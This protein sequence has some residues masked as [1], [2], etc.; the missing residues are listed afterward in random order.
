MRF[1]GL[2]N[3]SYLGFTG[4]PIIKDEEELT[5]NIFGEYVSVYD[6]KRAIEDEATLP[7]RYINKAEKLDIENPQLDERMAEILEDENLDEDQQKKLAYLFQKNYPILTSE[8]RLD[9]IAKDLVWHFNERGYQGLSLI[10]ISE[11]TRPY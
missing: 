3:A 7:L 9:A 1:H 8:P 10:H 11:P 6:F 5:K 4:T 2:P